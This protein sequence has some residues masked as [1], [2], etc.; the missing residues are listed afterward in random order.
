M[1][2]VI[3]MVYD[4]FHTRDINELS[5]LARRMPVMAF[6]F[7]FFV[8]SSIGLP[9]LNGFWSEF[10][11]IL[12]AFTSEHLGIGFGVVAATGIVLGAVYMLHMTAKVIFGPLK[13]PHQHDHGHGHEKSDDHGTSLPRDLSGREVAI[14]VPL[15]VVAVVLGVYPKLITDSVAQNV[16]QIRTAAVV[17][18]AE[19]GPTLVEAATALAANESNGTR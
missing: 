16:Q 6:F 9:V 15:A 5:G 14:L 1:F 17:A 10:G 18:P 8:L 3:G 2:L 11:T 12:G 13:Y 4:R 7:V 19:N